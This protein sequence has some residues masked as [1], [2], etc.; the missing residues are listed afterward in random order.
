[1]VRIT[2]KV[3]YTPAQK[4]QELIARERANQAWDPVKMNYFLEGSQ[5]RSE[6]M[7]EVTE[8]LER[9]PIMAASAKTY[10]YTKAEQ[11]ELAG[12][13]VGRLARYLEIDSQ[14]KTEAR[15][16]I[17]SLMDPSAVIRSAVH[18]VLWIPALKGNGTKE[19]YNYW[20][21]GKSDTMSTIYGCFAMTELAHGSNIPGLET[22][23]TFDEATDEF[24]INTPHIGATKWWIGGAAHTSTHAVVFAK[25]IVK[26]EDYG[27]KT[28]VVPLRDAHH[29]VCPGVT[30][31]DI[32]AKMGR[33]GIDNGWI[34]FSHVRIPRFFMLQKFCKVSR[35]GEVTLPP[36]EQ[37]SYSAL[38]G[39]RVGVVFDSYRMICRMVTIALRYAVGRT[40]FPKKGEDSELQILD[41]ALH[42]RRL[43]PY[44][45]M[46]YVVAGSMHKLR[47]SMF[48]IMDDIEVAVDNDDMSSLMESIDLIKGFFVDSA[49]L[50]ATMSWTASACIDECRQACGGHG[51]SAYNGF[52]KAFSDWSVQCTWEGDNNMLGVTA[53]RSI[54]KSVGSVLKGK[55]IKGSWAFL[56]QANDVTGANA[57][58][59]ILTSANDITDLRKFLQTVQIGI[60]R[61]AAATIVDLEANG[62]DLNEVG[63]ELIGINKLWSAQ[64]L[65]TE[66]VHRVDAHPDQSVVPYL[67][68]QGQYFA[69]GFVLQQCSSLFLS[70][71]LV[72]PK[73]FAEINS[74]V[75]PRLS[76]EIRP[77]V[78]NY[79]DS[80]QQSDIVL[81]APIG[82][83]NGEIYTNY[84]STVKA[85][86]P[87]SV[88]KAP[89]SA[90][91]EA[92]LARGDLE[93]R[94]RYEKTG[95][96]AKILSK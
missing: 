92:M 19:Q 63:T 10:D 37:L 62:N 57:E 36:L 7:A 48:K 64:Y 27:I 49:A 16:Q 8:Q 28:F 29:N 77:H 87:E 43:F 44:L 84:F 12:A 76:K 17:I 72:S 94:D 79:T 82:N 53:G 50:K 85:Q 65:L 86:N 20:V 13:R 31:G 91:L 4:P 93:A 83:Y 5:E 95:E 1:M 96:T 24:V 46:A 18:L 41:Y 2:S 35:D 32:G 15:C 9:D 90:A 26:G 30:V 88:T 69:V 80:F 3:D 14:E 54:L 61:A 60:I 21:N 66:F 47:A 75:L 81:N 74:K 58:K 33:D 71:S 45:S 34:Q 6:L 11:R 89:Y 56:N 23:A 68:L 51:Y 25:L 40:Q 59:Y 22:T 70:H 52:G 67:R 38:L 39:G 73:V 78:I 42:Q 55:T